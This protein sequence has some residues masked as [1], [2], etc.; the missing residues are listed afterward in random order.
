MYGPALVSA[1]VDGRRGPS[2]PSSSGGGTGRSGLGLR[3]RRRGPSPPSTIGGSTE[4]NRRP[5]TRRC[6]QGAAAKLRYRPL[7]H[8]GETVPWRLWGE[9]RVRESGTFLWLPACRGM[10]FPAVVV[11]HDA[12]SSFLPPLDMHS[13][14][15]CPLPGGQRKASVRNMDDAREQIGTAIS[16]ALKEIKPISISIN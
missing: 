8:G 2:P 11:L 1:Y 15:P 4:R 3:R 7:W 13:T 12:S 16:T 14:I 6:V 10:D 5:G 9:G